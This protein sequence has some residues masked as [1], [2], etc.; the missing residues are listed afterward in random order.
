MSLVLEAWQWLTAPAS[1]QGSGSIP[2]RLLEHVAITAVVVG[3]AVAIAVPAGVLVGHRRRGGGPLVVLTGAARSV[4][5]LGVLTLLALWMGIGLAAPIIALVLLAVPPVLAAAYSGVAAV[6][7]DVADSARAIG[8]STGQVVRRVEMPLASMTI[9]GGV[10]TAAVQVVSTATLAAYTADACL[11]R[12]IFTCQ[13]ICD[14]AQL[15][16]GSVLVIALALVIEGIFVVIRRA[17]AGRLPAPRFSNRETSI[18][19]TV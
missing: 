15:I 14:Y 12:F 11:G 13:K 2:Q 8:M 1:W 7:A 18:E 3:I 9:A 19:R 17:L 16:G 10:Q 6:G 4:P 5:T